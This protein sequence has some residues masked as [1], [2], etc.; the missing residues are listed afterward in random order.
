MQG[1]WNERAQEM[2]DDLD[3]AHQRYIRNL[4]RAGDLPGARV[5]E[6]GCGIGTVAAELHRR[7][8]TVMGVDFSREMVRTARALH[9]DK[10]PDHLLFTYSGEARS[11]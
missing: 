5:L 4:T 2:G 6:L 11:H 1:F 10:L 7:G 3:W 9:G 8:A